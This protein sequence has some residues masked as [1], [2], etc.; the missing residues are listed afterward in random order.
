M[1][2]KQSIMFLC[3]SALKTGSILTV[4]LKLSVINAKAAKVKLNYCLE[5]TGCKSGSAP[6]KSREES[7]LFRL[8]EAPVPAAQVSRYTFFE[9]V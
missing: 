5:Q 9:A 1:R 4:H 2:G 8:G 7:A 6:K 3:T